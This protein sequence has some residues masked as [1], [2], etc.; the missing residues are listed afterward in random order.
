MADLNDLISFANQLT[1]TVEDLVNQWTNNT[2]PAD[3]RDANDAI[4]TLQ[5]VLNE[6][7]TQT[8]RTAA[9]CVAVLKAQNTAISEILV[10]AASNPRIAIP[11][12]KAAILQEQ[13]LSNQ[14]AIGLIDLAAVFAP[15]ASLLQPGDLTTISS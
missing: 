9:Q 8:V 4:T 14:D 5:K 11:A 13:L 12:T 15:L 10:Q 2:Q 3:A 1:P 6:A 7:N